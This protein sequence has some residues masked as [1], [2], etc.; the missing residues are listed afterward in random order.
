MNLV[1]TVL[2]CTLR[3]PVSSSIIQS[4]SYSHTDRHL[5]NKITGTHCA[6]KK[7]RTT[8]H[9]EMIIFY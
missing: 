8:A 4:Q 5:V 1:L 3:D 7:K 6:N 2:Q 9:A